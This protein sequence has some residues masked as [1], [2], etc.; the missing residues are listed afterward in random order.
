MEFLIFACYFICMIY[1]EKVIE[2]KNIK[3]ITLIFYIAVT[4]V[5]IMAILIGT[6][7]DTTEPSIT[8]M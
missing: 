6:F 5:M 1:F 2:K 4:P 3:H 8:F 7:L